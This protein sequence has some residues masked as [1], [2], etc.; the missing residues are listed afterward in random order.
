MPAGVA[1]VPTAPATPPAPKNCKAH[2]TDVAQSYLSKLSPKSTQ[3]VVVAGEGKTSSVNQVTYWAKQPANCWLKVKTMDGRNGAAGWSTTPV[4]G[5]YLSPIGVFGLS[6]AGGR[7]KNPG[8][9]LPY[10]YGPGT[11]D[12]YGYRMNDSAVQMFDYVVAVN[13]NRF[14]GKPP[15]DMNRPD[16]SIHDGGIWFHVGGDGATKG[17]ISVTEPEMVWVLKWLEPT[18]KPTMI[19]GPTSYIS[20]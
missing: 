12:Q 3:V 6:D 10:H 5:S 4:D 13:F 9:K 14:T 16:P 20:G 7:L 8:T 15:R 1:A 18:A 11:W 17:C 19:M 2:I